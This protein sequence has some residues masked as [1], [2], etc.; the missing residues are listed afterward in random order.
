MTDAKPPAHLR[1]ARVEKVASGS[2]AH[3][4]FDPAAELGFSGDP[5]RRGGTADTMLPVL[6]L[7]SHDVDPDYDVRESRRNFDRVLRIL[8]TS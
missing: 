5:Q 7:G 1:P 8:G 2:G 4:R 6:R 3:A